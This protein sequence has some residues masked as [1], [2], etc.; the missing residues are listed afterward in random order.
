[1]KQF[2]EM[3]RGSISPKVHGIVFICNDLDDEGRLV[4]GVRKNRRRPVIVM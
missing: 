3:M 2:P 1:M 4:I